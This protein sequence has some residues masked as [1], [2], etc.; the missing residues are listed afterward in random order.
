VWR[1][2]VRNG[3]DAASLID[4]GV[5]AQLGAAGI[6]AP[7]LAD[8]RRFYYA[9]DVALASNNQY[10]YLHIGVGSGYR[11]H[12][13]EMDNHNAFYALRDYKTFGSMD[14]LQ[15]DGVTPIVPGDLVDVTA[16]ATA[17]VPQ[18][19]P[20]WKLDLVAGGGWNGEKVLAET[21]TFNNRVFVTTFRPGTAGVNCHPALGTNR[22]YVMSLF[23]G[24]P[25]NN[26]DGSTG[27]GPL[28][29]SDRYTE[30][31][32]A[33]PPETIFIFT[34]QGINSCVGTECGLE[35]FPQFPI[36]TFWTQE[37]I[38]GNP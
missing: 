16:N 21:R 8:T 15:Y 35:D 38:E 4:G 2:D 14:Q 13:Q 17:S 28:T 31:E 25:I 24:A 27:T 33:P 19:S 22:Q 32:G 10:S 37:S 6:T 3:N 11:E 36:R 18:G 1:F 9:P 12:P 26:R 20:G 30:W 34:D 29:E 23:T 7:T 5:I